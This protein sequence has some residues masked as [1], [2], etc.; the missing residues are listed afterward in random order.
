MDRARDQ[1]EVNP[2]VVEFGSYGRSDSDRVASEIFCQ[3]MAGC[4]FQGTSPRLSPLQFGVQLPCYEACW[5][6]SSEE[7]CFQQLQQH[8]RQLRVS[9]AVRMLWKSDINATAI[10]LFECSS[11]GMFVLIKGDISFVFVVLTAIL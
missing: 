7:E 3:D 9:D 5:N 1:E 11:F 6:A 4:I 10:P 2:E 8:P